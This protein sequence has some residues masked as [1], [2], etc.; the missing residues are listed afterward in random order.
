MRTRSSLR[1]W[2]LTDANNF[3]SAGAARVDNDIRPC[4]GIPATVGGTVCASGGV[5]VV[6][7]PLPATEHVAVLMM[8]NS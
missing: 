8:V 5:Q 7:E 1:W 6:G 2:W 4:I 3:Q